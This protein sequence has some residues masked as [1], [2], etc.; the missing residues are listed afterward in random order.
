MGRRL[1]QL[2]KQV[3]KAARYRRLSARIRQGEVYLGLV[4]FAG[5]AGDRREL[6][7]GLR[8]ARA[9]E[10]KHGKELGARDA[11]LQVHR[12]E[13]QVLEQG[14]GDQRDALSEMEAERRESESVRHYQGRTRDDLT[15][16]LDVMAHDLEDLS[17]QR[18][19]AETDS[20]SMKEDLSTSQETLDG[21]D[22]RLT[23]CGKQAQETGA[24]LLER[25]HC[26]CY[27]LWWR[28]Y[29]TL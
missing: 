8:T 22:Q 26:R 18:E 24:L 20:S 17:R 6:R 10:E 13:I 28:C 4:K 27:R 3:E 11:E 21:A 29:S 12:D 16:R 5:L 9:E 14:V 1:R 19:R 2:E 7:D 23:D 25:R 15:V